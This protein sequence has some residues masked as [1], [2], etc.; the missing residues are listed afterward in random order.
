MHSFLRSESGATAIEYSMI[1]ALI[2]LA[3]VGVMQSLGQ[4]IVNVLYTKLISAF[5]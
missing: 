2:F 4:S 1:A 3:I 5:S